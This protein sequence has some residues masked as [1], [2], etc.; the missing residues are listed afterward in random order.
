LKEE[1]LMNVYPLQDEPVI[2]EETETL[3]RITL[4]EHAPQHIDLE[5]GWAVVSQ[6][7]AYG[8]NTSQPESSR[9]QVISAH[10]RLP[11]RRSRVLVAAAILLLALLGAGSAGTLAHWFGGSTGSSVA[12]AAI[13][14]SMQIS[15]GVT[16]T[17]TKGYVDPKHLVLYFSAQLSSELSRTYADAMVTASTIQGKD[18]KVTWIAVVETPAMYGAIVAPSGGDITGKIFHVTWHISGVELFPVISGIAPRF[19]KGDWTFRFSI[20][21]HH[22]VQEPL[23]LTFPGVRPIP[24]H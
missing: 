10:R 9:R 15:N 12:Y 1:N 14:Q 21:F 8:G 23:Q 6:H 17:A 22:E 24:I 18:V 11:S 2:G 4:H 3:L 13:N 7:M 19:I 16:L 20:P 5:H